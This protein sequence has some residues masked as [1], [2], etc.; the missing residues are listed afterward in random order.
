MFT[1]KKQWHFCIVCLVLLLS[2]I[3]SGCTKKEEPTV[4]KKPATE[5]KK[6]GTINDSVLSSITS[7]DPVKTI[8]VATLRIGQQ[9]YEGLVDINNELKVVPLVAESWET[10]DNKIWTFKIRKGIY[11]HDDP[12]FPGGKG[13][14]V[15]AKDVKYS[16]ERVLDPKAKTVG[17]WIFSGIVKGA[18]KYFKGE[19]KE[20]QGFKVIDD[21]TF[22]IELTKP[23]YPLLTRLSLYLC[24]IVPKEAVEK[25]KQEFGQHPVGTGPF[26]LK[27]FVPDNQIVL[28]KNPAYW[29]RDKNGSQI[30][31]IDGISIRFIRDEMLQFKEFETG[32]LD[33]SDIPTAIYPNVVG[34]DKKPKGNYSKYQLVT[35]PA[36]ETH[37]Y[38]FIMSKK[39]LGDKKPLRQAI[40]YAVDKESI[41][42]HV[43][44]GRAVAAK[45]VI[46][47]SLSSYN[48][49]LKGYNY[50][51]QMAREKLKEAGYPDGKG[52]PE[53]KLVVDA[54]VQSEAVASAI[55]SQLGQ[56][57][58]KIKLQ[59]TQFNTLLEM[60]AQQKEPIFR[61]WFAAS[62]PEPELFFIQFLSGFYPPLGF[63][64]ARYSNPQ[65]DSLF[66]KATEAISEAD[67]IRYYRE[68]ERL[69]VED[70]PWVF[71]YH[72]EAAKIIQPYINNYKFNG[73]QL[74]RYKYVWINK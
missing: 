52:L 23:F 12:A 60:A 13:R 67:R 39:P 21:Y 71:L 51:L 16:L 29:E 72:P 36:I 25:Y 70:A 66:K 8:D 37:Y 14:E 41:V 49:E 33:T 7:F 20:V 35:A 10:T 3:I 27:K 6:G 68:A 44:K 34:I 17:S 56:I 62:Y 47:P 69:I 26:I 54:G 59:S 28:A 5:I 42:N 18:D 2:T 48:P 58:I 43:L 11:F 4:T 38:A 64:F 53:L 63:N 61:L 40:N 1:L 9:I 32:N 74:N 19:A 50:N 57:G 46:P 24:S 31:Y 15:T 30:P 65:F 45:G 22:R 55:Q 73:L